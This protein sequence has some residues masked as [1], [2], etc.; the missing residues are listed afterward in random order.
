MRSGQN[1]YLWSIHLQQRKQ[2]CMY[3]HI[4]IYMTKEKTN[5]KR[6]MHPNVHSSIIYNGQ[7]MKDI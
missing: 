4:Y 3:I 7:D 1:P 5:S 2:I 6:C